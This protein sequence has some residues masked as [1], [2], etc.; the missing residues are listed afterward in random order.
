MCFL[1]IANVQKLDIIKIAVHIPYLS[2]L[3][4][5]SRNLKQTMQIIVAQ[6]FDFPSLIY[7]L[8]ILSARRRSKNHQYL[9]EP[10]HVLVKVVTEV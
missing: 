3:S 8:F 1:Q 6:N 7:L 5:V 4:Y 9:N 2:A 10:T